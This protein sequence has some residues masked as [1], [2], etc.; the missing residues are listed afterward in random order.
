ML[1]TFHRY[2]YDSFAGL[3]WCNNILGSSQLLGS[4][5][6]N[7]VKA[8]DVIF[9]GHFGANDMS[10]LTR[11]ARK[12]F[13]VIAMIPTAFHRTDQHRQPW[14]APTEPAPEEG[15]GW[16]MRSCCSDHEMLQ[17]RALW[18]YSRTC[19]LLPEKHRWHGGIPCPWVSD[20]AQERCLLHS[21]QDGQIPKSYTGTL[22]LSNSSDFEG[23]QMHPSTPDVLKQKKKE[24][25]HNAISAV[26]SLNKSSSALSTFVVVFS[27]KEN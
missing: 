16:R 1:H 10:S 25:G 21:V 7:K 23:E 11:T 2:I 20:A 18:G 24:I 5:W 19:T 3:F 14:A 6:R 13:S 9:H 15:S 22:T 4:S 17:G 26:L 12:M 8:V 27:W